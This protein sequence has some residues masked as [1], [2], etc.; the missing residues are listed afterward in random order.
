MEFEMPRD[1]KGIWICKD[2]WLDDRLTALDKIICAEVD[3]LSCSDKGCYASNEYLAN[4]CKCSVAKVSASISKLC[5]LGYLEVASFD[6]R[7]RVL[8]SRLLNFRRQGNKIY[9]AD[10]QK[11]DAINIDSN[12]ESIFS[13]LLL[14][15]KEKRKELEQDH[16]KFG[17]VVLANKWAKEQP[18]YLSLTEEEQKRLFLEV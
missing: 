14:K 3:S 6:G 8:V 4:F 7:Y 17:A 18:E 15:I 11:V 16:S 5:E 12:I 10:T 9:E 2:I 13:L 1:F